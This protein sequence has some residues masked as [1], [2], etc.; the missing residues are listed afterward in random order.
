MRKKT[1]KYDQDFFGNAKKVVGEV[2]YSKALKKGKEKAYKILLK[3]V[4][5]LMA[6]IK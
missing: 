4:R 1:T 2:R 5:R 6:R 3:M